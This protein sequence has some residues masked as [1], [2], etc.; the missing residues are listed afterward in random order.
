MSPFER[1]GLTD[2]ADERAIKRAYARHL[3]STRPED[4]PQ[5][6][7]QLHAAYQAALE[8][9]REEGAH[10]PASPADRLDDYATTASPGPSAA[11]NHVPA[12]HGQPDREVAPAACFDIDAFCVE[13][14]EQA[15]IA[16]THALH[17]WLTDQQALWSLQLKAQ[18]GRY[19]VS[20]LYALA[21]PMATDRLETLLRFFDLDHALAG[22][23]PVALQR[24]KRR[25]RLAWQL[26][27]DDKAVLAS[28]LA[29]PNSPSKWHAYW[30][31]RLLK[32]PFS[33]PRTLFV[34]MNSANAD[35]I[36]GFVQT[37]SANYPQDLP[38]SIRREQLDFWL[39]AADQ[40]QVTSQR[41]IL[42][43]ARSVAMLLLAIPLAPWISHVFTGSTAPRPVLTVVGLLMIPSGL[44]ALWMA[45]LKLGDWHTTAKASPSRLSARACL[46]PAMCLAGIVLDAGGHGQLGLVPIIPALWLAIRRYRHHHSSAAFFRSGPLRSGFVRFGMLLA[47]LLLYSVL[48]SAW[49]NDVIPVDEIIAATAMLL[50]TKAR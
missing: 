20:Q 42:G 32:R 47:V 25:C 38:A 36:A 34:A 27:I 3:R 23:D 15:R 9:C 31:V 37:V 16:T 45:W 18:T 5:G 41:L 40:Q 29:L 6:F 22:H 19:L 28:R 2:D 8:W 1:L 30:I 44:W 4:D 11:E 39:A 49:G 33:W 13:A 35:L 21:P 17:T 10:E 7:Q 50:W 26:E 48:V 24:L 12:W 46:V 14:F 43:A